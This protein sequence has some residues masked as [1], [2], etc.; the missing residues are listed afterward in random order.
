MTSALVAFVAISVTL[1]LAIV[2][3]IISVSACYELAALKREADNRWDA[4]VTH[5]R[6]QYRKELENQTS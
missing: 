5:S 4:F 6:Q 3:L 2:A 1:V